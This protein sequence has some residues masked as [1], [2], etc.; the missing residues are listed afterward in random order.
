MIVATHPIQYQVPLFRELARRPEID[1]KVLYVFL[2]NEKQQGIGFD[3]G[4]Q[5]DVPLLDGYS[6]SVLGNASREPALGS[7]GGCRVRGAAGILQR[8]RPDVL[9]V[10]GWQAAALVQILAAAVSLRVPVLLRCEANALRRRP[11][12]VSLAHR[13]LLSTLNGFLVIGRS[14]REF[15]EAAG[16]DEGRLFWCP[17]FVD[18]EWFAAAAQDARGQRDALRRTW[19]IPKDATCFLFAGKLVEKKRPKDL[20]R[21]AARVRTSGADIHLLVVGSGAEERELR[22]E[23]DRSGVPVTFTGFLN[24]TEI[25][26]AYAVADCLVLPSDFGETWGLVVNEAMACG[27][28]ALASE[29]VGCAPDLVDDGETGFRFPFGDVITL[30]DRMTALS[31]NPAMLA[32]LGEN[33]RRRVSGYS[34]IAA[35]NGT[36]QAVETVSGA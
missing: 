29:L 13:A 32:R 4:F 31:G 2:P 10:T 5:W 17:Y 28:P 7:F 21:A 1:L 9:L 25:P 23:A 24:Q 26:A 14:N 19:G 34:V 15:Y 8:E 20:I 6:W 22:D 16:I 11:W 27:L 30:G 35:A 12:A 33:A 18:N 36:L 3:V